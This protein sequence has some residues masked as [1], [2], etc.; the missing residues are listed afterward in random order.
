MK[1]RCDSRWGGVWEKVK[2]WGDMCCICIVIPLATPLATRPYVN[3]QRSVC[4][5][6][7]AKAR[8]FIFVIIIICVTVAC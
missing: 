4:I 6:W 2:P 7:C 1:V 8:K 5:L 3:S